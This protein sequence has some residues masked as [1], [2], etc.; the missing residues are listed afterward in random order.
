MQD[1]VRMFLFARWISTC[2]ADE[3]LDKDNIYQGEQGFGRT[4]AMS[5]LNRENEIWWVKQLQHFEEV[6]YPNY[7][8][9]KTAERTEI[10]LKEQW[11]N[12][13]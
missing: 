2:Y 8:E 3:Y 6:V 10:F 11:K 12:Q 13:N 5:A 4:T 7:V 9:N 1:L